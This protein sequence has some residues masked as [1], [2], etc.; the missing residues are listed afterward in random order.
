MDV[1]TQVQQFFFSTENQQR[2]EIFSSKRHK[3]GVDGQFFEC[4]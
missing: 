1:G 3:P 4:A 2:S